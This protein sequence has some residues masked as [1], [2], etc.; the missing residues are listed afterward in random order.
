MNA[1]ATAGSTVEIANVAPEL[2]NDLGFSLQKHGEQICYLI[3][4]E[5]NS[6]FYRIGLPEYTFISL[7]DGTTTVREALSHTATQLGDDA[8]TEHDAATICKWLIDSQLAHT[9]ASGTAERLAE[10]SYEAQKKKRAQWLNPIVLRLPLLRPDR[11]LAWCNQRFGGLIS[12]TAFSVWLFTII[13]AGE[14]LL[15]HREQLSA[16]RLDRIEVYPR[17]LTR[18]RLSKIWGTGSRGGHRHDRFCTYP[19][20]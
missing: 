6:K 9:E 7:L 15:I 10:A 14:Q 17:V 1:T 5:R 19:L 4:D 18:Y 8:F 12:W 11:M 16:N 20:C 13:M 2:R 3:E